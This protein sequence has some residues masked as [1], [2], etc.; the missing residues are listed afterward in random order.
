ME[1]IINNILE[2][3]YILIGLLSI[4]TAV[5]V[6]KDA[7]HPTR[8]GTA[9]FWLLLG[10]VFAFG[11]FIPYIIDGIIIICMGVLTFF[12]QVRIGKIVDV[13]EQKQNK[14]PKESAVR[15]L[16]LVSH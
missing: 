12:K 15:F 7:T 14:P 13:D 10:I 9:T 3:F 6:F 11:N 1:A 5:R 2:F 4:M 16:S 8:L